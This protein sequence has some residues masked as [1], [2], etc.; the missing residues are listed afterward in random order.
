MSSNTDKLNASLAAS[1][2]KKNVND[3]TLDEIDFLQR[4]VQQIRYNKSQTQAVNNRPMSRN[5]VCTNKDFIQSIR[6]NPSDRMIPALTPNQ[7]GYQTQSSSQ[8]GYQTQ[9]SNQSGYQ[10]QASNQ[11]GYQT[12]ASNTD[13]ILSVPSSTTRMGKRSDTPYFNPYE[14]GS[15]QNSMQSVFNQR[16]MQND[17]QMAQTSLPTEDMI[18]QLGLDQ[19]S[20]NEKFPGNVRNIDVESALI[21]TQSFHTPGQRQTS[22]VAL[23]RFELL[24]F[25]PQDVNHIIW[26]DGMPRGGVP[27][28]NDREEMY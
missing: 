12:Q 7:S 9:S 4:Y 22:S 18:N 3:L 8:S 23:D 10:T 21:H 1:F 11:S 25:D 24:P 17:F 28:R 2:S 26:R 27:S 19:R 20:L 13:R 6:S 5:P 15:R 16:T 14:Y